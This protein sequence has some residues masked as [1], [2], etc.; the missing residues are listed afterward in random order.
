MRSGNLAD[1]VKLYR[2]RSHRHATAPRFLHAWGAHTR[3]RLGSRIVC[4]AAVR[5]ADGMLGGGS[6]AL[7]PLPQ[8]RQRR[9]VDGAIVGPGAVARTDAV[10][11]VVRVPLAS[12]AVGGAIERG[13]RHTH[14][15]EV[16][17][18]CV[19]R[20]RR[21]VSATASMDSRVAA[22]MFLFLRRTIL[23]APAPGVV[24]L[25]VAVGIR[26]TISRSG[27]IQ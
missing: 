2:L 10:M 11:V 22:L 23:A 25:G 1:G 20:Q 24:A 15:Q 26:D 6:P 18:K 4:P 12:A 8:P 3:P 17:T 19:G 27:A 13:A 21:L 16:R 5:A 7:P 9:F 14:R